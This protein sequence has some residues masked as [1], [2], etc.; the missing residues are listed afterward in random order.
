MCLVPDVVIP[1]K[2]KAPDFDKYRGTGCP[3]SHLTMYVRKMAAYAHDDKVLIHYFQDSLTGASLDWYMQLLSSEVHSWKDRSVPV[4][5]RWREFGPYILF[6]ENPE[7]VE[8][9]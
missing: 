2:F 1:P 3:S 7:C 4:D 8:T 5:S 6:D 9:W